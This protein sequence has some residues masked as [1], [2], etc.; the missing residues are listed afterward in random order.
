MNCDTHWTAYLSALLTPT[1]A[2]LG[3]FIA[4]R[5]WRTT[6]NKLK[7]DLFERRFSV[8]DAAKTLLESIM[9]S[10]KAKDEELFKFLSGTREAKWLLDANVAEYL[11][12]EL[13]C[14]ALDLQCLASE[15]EGLP[16]GE[17]KSSNDHKRA[18]IKKWFSKQYEVLD[19]K[20]SPFLKL[21]H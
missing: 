10:G 16:I 19:E 8:Y 12:K 6:Q 7:H 20:F 13:Y 18:E 9:T 14:Q 3:S 21:E 1:I 4:Y 2:V 15:L 17:E 11:D 5:Q